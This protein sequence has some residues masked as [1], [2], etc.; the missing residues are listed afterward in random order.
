MKFMFPQN[1]KTHRMNTRD[2]PKC[3]VQHANKER[4]KK[5]AIIYMQNLL[6]ENQILIENQNNDH[7]KI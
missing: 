6:N 5:S 2:T 4:L 3:V 1:K 7:E